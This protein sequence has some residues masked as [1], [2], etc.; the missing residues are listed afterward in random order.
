MNRKFSIHSRFRIC[1]EWIILYK[2]NYFPCLDL[3]INNLTYGKMQNAL[4]LVSESKKFPIHKV[5]NNSIEAPRTSSTGTSHMFLNDNFERL[6]SSD[7][8]WTND[9]VKLNLH[10]VKLARLLIDAGCNID[11]RDYQSHET[12]IFKAIGANNFDLVKLFIVEGVDLCQRNL[13]GNDVLS[14][15]IQLGRFKIARLLVVVD[16]PIRLYSFF[17][18]VPTIEEASSSAFDQSELDENELNALPNSNQANNESSF[19]QLQLSKYEEFIQLLKNYTHQPRSLLDLSRLCVR[20]L[21]KKPISKHLSAL[22]YL[23][24][25]VVDLIL[26]RDLEQFTDFA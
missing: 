6:D 9:R 4:H 18:N 26:L 7:S 19:L 20:S 15:S 8:N 2:F 16:T 12:P 3:N 24:S 21:M 17:F 5:S 1:L 10:N 11:H 13:F 22:G 25:Q 23:P 14:R